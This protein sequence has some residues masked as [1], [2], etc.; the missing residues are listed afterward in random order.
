MGCDIHCYVEVKS[1]SDDDYGWEMVE[2]EIFT[3]TKFDCEYYKK[4]KTNRPFY[5]RNYTM[6]AILADVRNG[7]NVRPISKPKGLPNGISR[8]VWTKYYDRILDAHSQSY[9]TLRELVEYNYN[10]EF[11]MNN[12]LFFTHIE[13]LKTL[14]GL[15]DVRIVFWF[16]N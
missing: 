7:G 9:L 2:D 4:D 14:G 6:F 16:D 5:W 12:Q 15:D 10:D 13:E 8:S 1:S 11:V 3:Q